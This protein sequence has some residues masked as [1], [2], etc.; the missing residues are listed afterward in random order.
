[1][2]VDQK[3]VRVCERSYFQMEKEDG[4][5]DLERCEKVWKAAGARYKRANISSENG[6]P[7]AKKQRIKKVPVATPSD[8]DSARRKM[9][10]S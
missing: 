2:L 3:K 8:D 10:T 4:G 1:M 9:R 7:P 6:K 5:A